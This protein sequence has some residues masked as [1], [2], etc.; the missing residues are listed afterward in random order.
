MREAAARDAARAA[1]VSE[2]PRAAPRERVETYKLPLAQ[3]ARKGT[4][5]VTD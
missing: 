5:S 3:T 2:T 1:H 4:T